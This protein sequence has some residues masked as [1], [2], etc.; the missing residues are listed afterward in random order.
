MRTDPPVFPEPVLQISQL[1]DP[2]IAKAG[3]P[4]NS[5]YADIMWLPIVGPSTIA[6]LRTLERELT[7]HPNGFT[8]TTL[9]L[10]QRIGLGAKGGKHGPMWRALTRAS[11]YHLAQQIGP[12]LALA[13]ALPPLPQRLHQRLPDTMQTQVA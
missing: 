1:H 12:N 13:P 11:R 10:A 6:V 5:D 2:A 8:I 4:F 9:D 3:Y 7:Q